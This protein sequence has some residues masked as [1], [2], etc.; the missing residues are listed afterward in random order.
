MIVTSTCCWH[1]D[2]ITV[3]VVEAAATV[4]CGVAEHRRSQLGIGA[5]KRAMLAIEV[6][7]HLAVAAILDLR[8][9]TAARPCRR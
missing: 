5:V 7:R 1:P 9:K 2:H 3:A 4:E 8:G 6:N